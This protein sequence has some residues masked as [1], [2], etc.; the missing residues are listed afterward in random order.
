MGG[1]QTLSSRR[2]RIRKGR[3]KAKDEELLG[4]LFTLAF[5]SAS[6]EIASD[7]LDAI[8][9]HL[10]SLLP[11]TAAAAAFVLSRVNAAN[12]PLFMRQNLVVVDVAAFY[13][14]HHAISKR[15]KKQR[16]P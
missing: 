8:F 4:L 6:C 2:G 7:Y 9:Y 3:R 5:A 10:F 1:R 15:D 14:S 11:S 13:I 16:R 12:K